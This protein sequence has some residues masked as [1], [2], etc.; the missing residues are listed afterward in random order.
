[1]RSVL[2]FAV[3]MAVI[4]FCFALRAQMMGT[5]PI[6]VAHYGGAAASIS[7]CATA[8]FADGYPVCSAVSAYTALGYFFPNH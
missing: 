6:H 2:R 1:M 5:I 8:I 7:A 4:L 3:L